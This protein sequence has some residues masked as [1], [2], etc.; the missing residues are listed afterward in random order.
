MVAAGPIS[1]LFHV[2]DLLWKQGWNTPNHNQALNQWQNIITIQLLL[3]FLL[4]NL[5]R[6]HSSVLIKAPY[7]NHNLLGGFINSNSR[8]LLN[9]EKG[10]FH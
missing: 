6:E 8:I 10:I 9:I 3:T 7:L 1:V 2:S 4:H 5:L